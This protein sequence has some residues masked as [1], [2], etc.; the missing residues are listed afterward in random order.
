MGA[1]PRR[2]GYHIVKVRPSPLG[3]GLKYAGLWDSFQDILSSEHRGEQPPDE[4][5]VPNV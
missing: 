2:A 3:E 4:R 5:S 1:G